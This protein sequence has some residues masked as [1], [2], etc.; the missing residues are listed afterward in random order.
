MY[1]QDEGEEVVRAREIIDSVLRKRKE[2][3]VV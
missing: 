1:Q 3:T 2:S